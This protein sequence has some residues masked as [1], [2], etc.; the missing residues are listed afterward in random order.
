MYKQWKN[1]FKKRMY[2][3]IDNND[4]QSKNLNIVKF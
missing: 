4:E 2:K 3:T 1:S